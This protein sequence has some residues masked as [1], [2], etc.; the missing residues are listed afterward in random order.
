MDTIHRERGESSAPGASS[1]DNMMLSAVRDLTNE[2]RAFREAYMFAVSF[3]QTPFIVLSSN[4]AVALYAAHGG[5]DDSGF[6]CEVFHQVLSG[7]GVGS[8]LWGISGCFLGI[9]YLF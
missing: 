7:F 5:G 2:I 3:S 9:L 6:C 8:L 1:A 4:N